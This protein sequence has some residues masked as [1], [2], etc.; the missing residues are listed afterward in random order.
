MP[1]FDYSGG[2]SIFSAVKDDPQTVANTADDLKLRYV[3]RS[4]QG[5]N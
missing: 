1:A 4:L 5:H 2:G 3:G